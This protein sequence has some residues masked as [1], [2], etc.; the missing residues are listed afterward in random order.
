MGMIKHRHNHLRIESEALLRIVLLEGGPSLAEKAVAVLRQL[1]RTPVRAGRAW[2][3]WLRSSRLSGRCARPAALFC[4]W[5][6]DLALRKAGGG[7]ER[8]PGSGCI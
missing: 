5:A 2:N 3:G 8:R 7:W 6:V 4:S 1:V